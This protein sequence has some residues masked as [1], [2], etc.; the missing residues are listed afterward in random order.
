[1]HP[2]TLW[3]SCCCPVGH[4]WRL[5]GCRGQGLDGCAAAVVWVQPRALGAAL[6]SAV[7]FGKGEGLELMRLLGDFS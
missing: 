1:M 6:G 2:R 7:G 3:G 4:S 5:L